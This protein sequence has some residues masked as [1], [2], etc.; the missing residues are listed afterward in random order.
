M[1]KA[2]FQSNQN[3]KLFHTGLTNKGNPTH[4]MNW[5]NCTFPV[6]KMISDF[7]FKEGKVNI[8]QN[9]LP[10]IKLPRDTGP[11]TDTIYCMTTRRENEEEEEE[12]YEEKA[13]CPQCRNWL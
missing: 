6:F 10:S 7:D 13:F 2:R 8:Y 5:K 4:P 1:L 3:G 9:Y 11:I 12:G